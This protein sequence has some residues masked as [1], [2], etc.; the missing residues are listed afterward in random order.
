MKNFCPVC[1]CDPCDCDDQYIHDI[2]SM[3]WT[4]QRSRFH[5]MFFGWFWETGAKGV[6]VRDN[7]NTFF[8]VIT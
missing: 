7:S 1:D 6:G 5:N 4:W 8:F 2:L 3:L